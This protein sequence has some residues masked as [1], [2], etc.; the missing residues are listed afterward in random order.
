MLFEDTQNV[1]GLPGSSLQIL[2]CFGPSTLD[3]SGTMTGL[4]DGDHGFVSLQ[5]IQLY[6]I[7]QNMPGTLS[8]DRSLGAFSSPNRSERSMQDSDLENL[9]IVSEL[10]GSSLPTRNRDRYRALSPGS[11]RARGRILSKPSAVIRDW[12]FAHSSSPYP[13]PKVTAEL[14]RL[15]GLSEQ[16][17]KQCLSNLRAR[18]KNGS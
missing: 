6:N 7:E 10:C 9:N 16:Q 17:A 8:N 18:A 13:S 5:E 2:G 12:Y 4:N 3:D 11:H 1:L 14:A 15:S